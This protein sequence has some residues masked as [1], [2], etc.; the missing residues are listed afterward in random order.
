[1]LC[2]VILAGGS[3][4][5]FGGDKY[6]WQLSGRPIISIVASAL[7]GVSDTVYVSATSVARAE[8]LAKIADVDGFVLDDLSM[9]FGGPLRGMLTSIHNIPA[10][11]FLFVPGDLPWID[12]ATLRRFVERCGE[13]ECGSIIWG[14]GS[15]SSTI[16]YVDRDARRWIADL[17][18]YR[19]IYGRATDTLR[20]CGKVVLVHARNIVDD[21]RKLSSV[22]FE[23]EVRSP[24]PPP[25]H[26]PVVDD[27]RIRRRS[28]AF[29]TAIRNESA[30]DRG[31]ALRAYM[32]EART[33]V[34]MNVTHLAL[35]SLIDARRCSDTRSPEIDD[36]IGACSLMLG[37]NKAKRHIPNL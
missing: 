4:E 29:L 37:W 18:R 22:N 13:A 27:V 26:G 6:V 25:I 33:Y 31:R 36:I 20:I 30:G 7:S 34:E 3:S 12:A 32:Q 17:V 5:R 23:E 24:R 19:G 21:P 35:H 2:G 15:I 11:Q 8:L 10:D 16:Q 9:A 28:P 1:M 14:N